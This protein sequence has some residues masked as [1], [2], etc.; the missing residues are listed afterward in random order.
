MMSSNTWNDR[1]SKY[2]LI[3]LKL[4]ISEGNSSP[5]CKIML[6]LFAFSNITTTSI[7][8]ICG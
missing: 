5:M 7:Y 8:K 2:C 1:L 6:L 4:L 3:Y